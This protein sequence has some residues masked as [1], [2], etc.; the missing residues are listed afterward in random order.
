MAVLWLLLFAASLP[1]S[2]R[3]VSSADEP[4]DTLMHNLGGV[5]VTSAYPSAIRSTS[6]GDMMISAERVATRSRAFGE[7]DIVGAL[8]VLP[9]VTTIGDYGAGLTIDGSDLSQ[10]LHSIN[11]IP[12]I[13]PYRFGGIFSTFNT[14]HFRSATFSRMCRL[15]S[16]PSRLGGNIDLEPYGIPGSGSTPV[17]GTVNAGIL[18]SSATL[19][20]GMP[21]RWG[22]TASARVSYIDQIYGR[23]LT[24]ADRNI[25][26]NFMDFNLSGAL[27][28]DS[29]NMLKVDFFHNTDRLT[30]GDGN[31]AM[32]LLL[33]WHNNMAGVAWHHSSSSVT[34]NV[35]TF[36]TGFSNTLSLR[37]P[38]LL[39]KA[40]SGLHQGGVAADGTVDSFVF[41]RYTL[42]WG[43]EAN[44]YAVDPQW[45]TYTIEGSTTGSPRHRHNMGD[46]KAGVEIRFPFATGLA[47]IPAL[48]FSGVSTAAG[49][50]KTDLSPMLTLE[51]I[52]RRHTLRLHAGR[53]CQYL[54]LV[55]LSEI[56]LASN[57]WM[58]PTEHAP[59]QVMW[60]YMVSSRW[61]LPVAS[62][63]LETAVYYKRVFN[64]PE[65]FGNVIDIIDASYDATTHLRS[66]DGYNTGFN[67]DLRRESGM[68]TGSLNYSF[69][70]ARR[71]N[72]NTGEW[73]RAITETRHTIGADLSY[74]LNDRWTFGATYTYATGRP[75]TPVRQIYFIG[76][77]I[78]MEYGTYNSGLFPDYQR[79]DLSASYSWKT[80]TKSIQPL[81]HLVNFSLLNATGHRNV[82]MQYY[83]AKIDMGDYRLKRIYSLY[84]FIPSLSY[85]LSF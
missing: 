60:N 35:R 49:Y 85:T 69:G 16:S 75:Y 34:T 73:F 24:T 29:R 62:L 9:G 40:P 46:Y 8:K 4:S 61:L 71:K 82:D 78:G 22:I 17:A 66:Y 59:R 64:Q 30:F 74:R 54:H 32:D 58:I 47:A 25:R 53:Y 67:I 56:G 39:I 70:I 38:Q 10:T 23:F 5:T 51:H 6:S 80:R 44:I 12:V 15:P 13:F 14:S 52:T 36:Y 45:A 81:S 76:G 50:A 65:Y 77:S 84:R 41:N 55:G 3:A 7:A 21:L 20:T 27:R 72:P 48:K 43:A 83:I 18:S 68:L 33:N 37:Q 31:Y 57:F 19:R 1:V 11:G 79:L 28:I 42:A 2:A 63:K 26:Y